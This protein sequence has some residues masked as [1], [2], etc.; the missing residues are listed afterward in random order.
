MT[1]ATPVA[2][3]IGWRIDVARAELAELR[4]RLDGGLLTQAE[5]D[6]SARRIAQEL[7]QAASEE[8]AAAGPVAAPPRRFAAPRALL[9]GAAA[10][11]VAAVCAFVLLRTG[12]R[13]AD[14]APAGPQTA[15]PPAA[16]AAA[17]STATVP[18]GAPVRPLSDE[19][20]ERTIAEAL[21][22]T[23]ADPD[24]VSAWAM[25][26]HS[27]DMLGKFAE[28]SKAYAALARLAPG[29]AQVLADYADALA[30]AHGRT[31]DGEPLALVEKALALDP[32]NAKALALQGTAAFERQDYAQAVASWARARDA[33]TD[34]VFK[35]QIEAS[36]A[37]AQAAALGPGAAKPAAAARPAA[38]EA[39]ASAAPAR[40]SGRVT[41]ADELVAKAPPDATVYVFARPVAG[42][43]MPLALLR[44]RVRD[45]PLDFTLDDTM[46]M[47]PQARLSQAERVVIGARISVRG[48]V[49]PRS[50]DMQG[51]SAPVPVGAQGIRLEI[52]EVIK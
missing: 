36:L 32:R 20:L 25:L 9:V 34:P 41:L 1:A 52:G 10:L 38:P 18:P 11:L 4:E 39:G 5:H 13:A 2:P 42:S 15:A 45:L 31:L 37:E 50:G 40:V 35:A 30:V 17:A 24:N 47:V 7:L 19:Q 23:R 44:R 14:D 46:A 28:S 49:T 51:Y 3:A 43:R 16:D 26:A 33:S 27:Y 6:E 12:E 8:A 48:D 21:A 22:Q 29:D